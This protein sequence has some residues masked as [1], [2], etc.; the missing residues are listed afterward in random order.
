[1]HG[2]SGGRNLNAL[3]RVN[4]AMEIP[5]DTLVYVCIWITV[6]VVACVVSAFTDY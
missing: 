4:S 6:G 2:V 1:M 5:P 3:R